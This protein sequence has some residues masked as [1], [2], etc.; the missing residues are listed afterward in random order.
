MPNAQTGGGLERWL[1]VQQCSR[2]RQVLATKGSSSSGEATS[3]VSGQDES[4]IGE[5][6]GRDPSARPDGTVQKLE[7][8]LDRNGKSR[9]ILGLMW[10]N[11]LKERL[12]VV[13]L[14]Q[15][16]VGSACV[17]WYWWYW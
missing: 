9:S 2:S 13:S 11:G 4:R 7:L 15:Q 8:E 6:R 16:K 12:P 3:S 10:K 1:R 5:G 14:P 17:S